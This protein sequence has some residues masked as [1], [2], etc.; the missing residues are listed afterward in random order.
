[1]P[2]LKPRKRVVYFRISE[3]EFQQ[4]SQ[5]CES[6]GARSLSDLARS[7]MKRMLEGNDQRRTD[8]VSESL[9]VLQ[10]M[11][12]DLNRT[13]QRLNVLLD[14]RL[15]ETVPNDRSAQAAWKIENRS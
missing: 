9:S 3:D 14:A 11:M 2:V 5:L 4:F 6:T 13:V 7:A 8:R 1:M 10:T 12:Y 15:A